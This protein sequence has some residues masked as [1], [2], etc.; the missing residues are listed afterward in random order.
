MFS[1]TKRLGKMTPYKVKY[2]AYLKTVI[3]LRMYVSSSQ[4]FCW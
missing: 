1:E 3:I 4:L 2:N